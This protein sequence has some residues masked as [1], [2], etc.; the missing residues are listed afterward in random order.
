MP[1]S[2]LHMTVVV[3]GMFLSLRIHLLKGHVLLFCYKKDF[4]LSLSDKMT[5]M[6]LKRSILLQS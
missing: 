4:M 2:S 6:L 5:Q 1:G 3:G